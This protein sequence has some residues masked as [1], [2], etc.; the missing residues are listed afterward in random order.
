[1]SAIDFLKNKP[2][3]QGK[4]Q[5][6]III[7]QKVEEE[8]PLKDDKE[9]ELEEGEIN[10]NEE[11]V[12]EESLKVQKVK[13]RIKFVDKTK[14]KNAEIFDMNV[15]RRGLVERNL[16]KVVEA[17]P[18]I[19]PV[20]N[21]VLVREQ[22]L[23]QKQQ[24]QEPVIEP[25]EVKKMKRPENLTKKRRVVFKEQGQ[26]IEEAIPAVQAPILQE[27][28]QPPAPVLE[29]GA[30]IKRVRKV[31]QA[32]DKPL[33][34][35]VR[36]RF[37]PHPSNINIRA[38]SYYMNNR[39]MFI[40]FI[41][42]IFQPYKKELED[43][44]ENIS[45]DTIGQNAG[46][47]SLL[48]HQ[49]IVRDY[50]NIYTPYRGLLLY[51]G[52][53]SGKTC[54]SIAIAEGMK[55]SKR[56]IIMT[57][58]S[59]RRNYMEE[60]KKCGDTLY[61]RN[62][63]WEWISTENN[64]N[65]TNLETLSRVL[66]L[67]QE[68]VKKQ[69]GA[70]LINV[71][72]PS[73]FDT[74]NTE[75]KKSLDLQLDEMI[76]SKYTFINYNGL[77]N[78]ALSDLTNGYTQN[79]FDNSVVIIDEGHNL[80]SR[81]VNKIKKGYSL[82]QK[83]TKKQGE[84]EN[85]PTGEEGEDASGLPKAL[86][87][88]LYEYLM[89]AQNAKVIVLSGTPVINYPNEFGVLFNLLRGYIKTWKI[90]LTVTTS[91]KID[92]ETLTQ[93]FREGDE[94]GLDYLDYSP[95]TKILTITHNPFGFHN[96][97]TDVRGV[98]NG[99]VYDSNYKVTDTAFLS[100]VLGILRG[101]GIDVNAS[102]VKVLQ[103][104]AL[105]DTFDTF[106]GQYIDENSL[107]L[108]NVDGLKRRVVGLS[109]YFRSAQEGL[110]PKYEKETDY[111][112]LR[113]PMSDYQF[114][115]YEKERKKE[116]KTE[117]ASKLKK[118]AALNLQNDV[119]KEAT[120]SYRIFSRLRCNYAVEDRPYPEAFR[121]K[122]TQEEGTEE[123]GL[124]GKLREAEKKRNENDLSN[125]NEG[126]IEGEDILN[127]LGGINYA[128]QVQ[129]TL[130]NINDNPEKY[131][132]PEGLKKYSPKFLKML[133]N[134]QNPNNV[135]LHL[136]YS[137]IRTLEGIG[138]F[139]LVLEHNGFTRFQIKKNANGGWDMVDSENEITRDE[140]A[141]GELEEI[142]VADIE[143]VVKPQR[144]RKPTF[145][146]YTGTESAEEKEIVRNIYNGDWENVPTNIANRLRQ[147]SPNNN[148]GEVI[149]VFMITSSGSEGINL[150]NTRFVHIMEPYWH[151]VRQEQ[152]IGRAR[153]I[154]SHKNLPKELQT[155]EV[156]MYL[157]V[158]SEEQLDPKGRF[159]D[160]TIE[161]KKFDR[162]KITAGKIV[163]SDETLYEI[164]EIKS[165]FVSQLTDSIKQTSFDCSIYSGT[166]CISFG[167]EANS[168]AFS[169]VPNYLDQSDD[170]TAA[171]NRQQ[172]VVTYKVFTT[173][174]GKSYKVKNLEQ[175][176]PGVYYIY[177]NVE[178]PLV[179]VGTYEILNNGQAIIKIF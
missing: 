98:Y 125:E 8:P 92:K 39:E 95:S 136:V 127:D 178:N 35:D 71:T 28:P 101:R 123:E 53:G 138:I 14:D 57:P 112:L 4:K 81:I 156:F 24:E 84:G 133:E 56:V 166:N 155:V 177:D 22:V 146:L 108:K 2:I 65:K 114:E 130:R 50:I 18:E 16:T 70:W 38:S 93:M 150:R 72:K 42:R 85:P 1:M 49:K 43:N 48:T 44:I 82:G 157:T 161:L 78:K 116:R 163:T 88:K 77:R 174:N 105:P 29:E 45:C 75:Q 143:A 89:S 80:I 15:F 73:N 31:K 86:S 96:S 110:L 67:P 103:Q 36:N 165:R 40:K 74:L 21:E 147:I 154:C 160:V 126:E 46:E 119:Y 59:L 124:V 151:P 104:K 97:Y 140:E 111:H 34:F 58:A 20:V 26:Q 90:P 3:I 132:S 100:R 12:V 83:Q 129:Q 27:Q 37:P 54:T 76:R 179:E 167:N 142:N 91:Q 47:F 158:F 152:V 145:V 128:E 120:S 135:G 66:N 139:S 13:N 107:Q 115:I 99:V 121:S 171:L 25:Q 118:P 134:I 113:I 61:K 55:T 30:I 9:L 122:G 149:K 131:L 10:E 153:R 33:T 162:S 170:K 52:L 6:R 94:K 164:S 102:Q 64:S 169:Y 172:Q 141:T 106:M 87:L 19:K 23:E 175:G 109:S 5:N 137:Q 51:H 176:V 69:K 148:M 60:L 79:L 17:R 62:Q 168:K 32:V 117:K 63:F 173:N 7:Q 11:N 144:K 68:Y 159:A 41:N